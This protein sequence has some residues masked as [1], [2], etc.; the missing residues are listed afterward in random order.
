VLGEKPAQ[1]VLVGGNRGL[2]LKSFKRDVHRQQNV[3]DNLGNQPPSQRRCRCELFSWEV[4]AD[5]DTVGKNPLQHLRHIC[6][7]NV[8]VV[9]AL[10][11]RFSNQS[12]LSPMPADGRRHSGNKRK[13]SHVMNCI[14][15]G[16]DD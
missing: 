15:S 2:D 11:A 14:R 9:R 8:D 10:A 4:I 3:I 16:L 12:F 5:G 13:A 6:P 1:V 7:S